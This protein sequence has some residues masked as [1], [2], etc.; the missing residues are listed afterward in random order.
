MQNAGAQRPPDVGPLRTGAPPA[1]PQSWIHVVAAPRRRPRHPSVSRSPHRDA[2]LLLEPSPPGPL[3]PG[4]ESY[5]AGPFLDIHKARRVAAAPKRSCRAQSPN[6]Q[7]TTPRECSGPD[8]GQVSTL[9]TASGSASGPD[10]QTARTATR[11]AMEFDRH[12]PGAA[13]TRGSGSANRA[14]DFD[15]STP[16]DIAAYWESAARRWTA[17]AHAA[18]ARPLNPGAPE[19]RHRSQPRLPTLAHHAPP[20]PPLA[21]RQTRTG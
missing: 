12:H 6:Q 7:V 4:V 19:R 10:K 3:S 2:P 8:T 5:G 14:S 20:T 18:A 13:L 1:P 15:A 21:H 11:R 9:K 16:A 17:A